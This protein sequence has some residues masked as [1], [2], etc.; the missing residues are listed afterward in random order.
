MSPAGGRLGPVRA[1]FGRPPRFPSACLIGPAGDSRHVPSVVRRFLC[2][3][4]RW[5]LYWVCQGR[6]ML[7][8]HQ[9]C[10]GVTPWGYSTADYVL[11]LLNTER[12]D[13]MKDL[14]TQQNRHKSGSKH[15]TFSNSWNSIYRPPS[16]HIEFFLI[17]PLVPSRPAPPVGSYA[18]VLGFPC[19]YLRRRRPNTQ[20]PAKAK[21]L[22]NCVIT[23]APT[24][25]QRVATV[26]GQMKSNV[27][28]WAHKALRQYRLAEHITSLNGV[29]TRLVSP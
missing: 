25:S 19:P 12:S 7:V 1:P 18:N 21:P 8:C 17:R 3:A 5:V 23:N 24:G 4:H 10:K 15:P 13:I 22:A 16:I 6:A 26:S 27:A 29:A 28:L 20:P 14:R 11:D 9:F 2:Q